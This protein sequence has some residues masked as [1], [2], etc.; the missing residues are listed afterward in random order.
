MT[1]NMVPFE[2]MS[3]PAFMANTEVDNDLTAHASASFPVIS[4][5]G[6]V[7]TIVRGKERKILTHPNDNSCPVNSMLVVIVKASPDKSKTYYASGYVSGAEGEE[8][9]PTCFSN[10]GK[11]P[12]PSV[13]T[14]QCQ[15]CAACKWNAFGT[16]RGDN[17]T[18]SKGKACS[19]FVRIVV[20][21]SDKPEELYLLRVPPASIRNLGEYGKL[22]SA[23]HVSYQG[24][25]TKISF[26]VR[27]ATPR[28]LFEPVGF[29]QKKE[30]FDK[31][32]E[33]SR[34]ELVHT[35]LY[36]STE[37]AEAPVAA[38]ALVK[39][40]AQV[41]APVVE[42]PKQSDYHGQKVAQTVNKQ[43]QAEDLVQT[44]ESG[45]TAQAP[46]AQAKPV[47]ADQATAES[48]IASVMDAPVAQA[49]QREEPVV[50]QDASKLGDALAG[51]G[52][53]D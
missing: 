8:A 12:D 48:L 23:R 25:V 50:V 49:P 6:K 26:D 34:S 33:Q 44:F 30:I 22:L 18:T 21:Q 32:V 2:Q 35:M 36:G 15:S 16:A 24:V 19:D 45:V 27:E 53:D 28:L 5:K 41:Q 37:T 47:S 42:E 39:P 14:P 40:V 43:A 46:K 1:M 10:D 4:I 29:V 13:A 17:G 31:V 7:F 9:R 11:K 38:P 52:F 51:I 20:C 3:A